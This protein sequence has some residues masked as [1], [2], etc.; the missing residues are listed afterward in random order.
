M[1]ATTRRARERRLRQVVGTLVLGTL[2]LVALAGVAWFEWSRPPAADAATMCPASGPT[3]QVVLMVDTTDPLT[4][5]QR[6]A[7]DVLLKDLVQRRVPRDTLLSVYA[8]GGDFR[9]DAKPLVELC[10]P[11]DGSDRSELTANLQRL[12]AQYEQRFL[13]PLAAQ[14]DALM[15]AAPAERSPLLEAVQLV[16]IDAFRR[17]AEVH[18]PRRL[19]ILSDLLH[20]TPQYSMYREVPDFAAFSATDYGRHLRA[21]LPGVDVE[22]HVLLTAPRL[23]TRRQL[24]FWES[25][26]DQA[27]ARVVEV[28]PI[29]G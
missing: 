3:G 15:N 19:V 18:G 4:F 14:S 25:W 5:T 28:R 12:R 24:Q 1:A 17:H 13:Q 21:D 26:F 6:R 29:E 9:A 11:G 20:N 2:A 8:V 23:Q 22:L 7:W 16:G 27:G 10:N